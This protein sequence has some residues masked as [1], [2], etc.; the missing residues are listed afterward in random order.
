MKSEKVP[1]WSATS[2]PPFQSLHELGIGLL[3]DGQRLD[4]LC[5]GDAFIE[6]S[7]NVG[8]DLSYLMVQI[9]EPS[10]EEGEEYDY[11]GHYQE[12]QSGE[13][14][15]YSQ[16]DNRCAYYVKRKV[17]AVEELPGEKLAYPGG[18]AHYPGVDVSHAVLIV[19]VEAELLKMREGPVSHV[20]VHAHLCGKAASDSEIADYGC[21]HDQRY[22]YQRK[23]NYA[24]KGGFSYEIVQ[25]IFL[26]HRSQYV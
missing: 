9:E 12:Y 5:S 10:L 8:V 15:V 19:V 21:G 7:G 26:E 17:C 1:T 14:H 25:R 4:S 13:L 16:H 18:I 3:F 22:I 2:M 11:N 23:R 6:V 24:L 20:A